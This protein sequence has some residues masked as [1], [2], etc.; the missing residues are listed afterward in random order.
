M[1]PDVLQR[2]TWD[3][4]PRELGDLCH[5]VN[6]TARCQLLTHQLGLEC[7]LLVGQEGLQSEVCKEQGSVLTTGEQWKAALIAK[8]WT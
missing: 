8:R 1:T 3:G 6:K 5:K 4:R 2:L 7:R